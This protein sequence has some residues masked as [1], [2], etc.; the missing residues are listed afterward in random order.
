MYILSCTQSGIT[1]TCPFVCDLQYNDITRVLSPKWILVVRLN[2]NR[3][4]I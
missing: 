3:F 2:V 4:A 1:N